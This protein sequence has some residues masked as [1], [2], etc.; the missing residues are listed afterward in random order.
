MSMRSAA[1]CFPVNKATCVIV[2]Q[3]QLNAA[4]PIH[5][6]RRMSC[7]R[8]VLA[9]FKTKFITPSPTYATT[10]LMYVCAGVSAAFRCR[11]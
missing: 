4:H 8:H 2:S 10:D 6:S 7:I 3:V 9:G 11:T 1:A 5:R